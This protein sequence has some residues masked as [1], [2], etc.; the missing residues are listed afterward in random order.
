VIPGT[1]G[2]FTPRPAL[3][4]YLQKALGYGITGSTEE[5][6]F[7]LAIG[8][9]SNG[10]G[11]VFDTVKA[12]LGPYS[13]VLPAEA[14]MVSKHDTDAERPTSL[15]ATLAG[16][17]L[18]VASE[19]KEGQK[20]NV[21][22]IKAHTGDREMQ[23]RKMR[24]DSFTFTITHKLWL[25]TNV[26]PTLDHIDPATKGRLHFTPFD[27]RWNRPGEVD[28]NPALP[29]GDKTLMAHLLTTEAEGILAWLIRGAVMYAGEGLTPP[30]EVT[31]LTREYV[32]E[33]DHF[34]RWLATLQRCAPKLGTLAAE[35]FRLFNGWCGG[36]S[37][38]TNP[39]NANAFGRA[40]RS[41]GVEYAE[42]EQGRKWGIRAAVPVPPP[43]PNA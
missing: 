14:L 41:R 43:P 16:A 17:R 27:R 26:R 31:A 7:F 15:A 12:M 13:V 28:R 18:V 30:D 3:A 22:M 21:A 39:N 24:Q 37:V 36:E 25:L 34:G 33:Q 5:H 42:V 29:D 2:R 10:K 1:V 23:A 6:K 35:L 20:L 11:V 9:G 32:M 38:A 4:R 8:E 40:L 19:S